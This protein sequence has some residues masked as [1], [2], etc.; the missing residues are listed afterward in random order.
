M[1]GRKHVRSV[2][3]ILIV[4]IGF[5]WYMLLPVSLA[6]EVVFLT[7]PKGATLSQTADSLK[8]AGVIRSAAAFKMYMRLRGLAGDIKPGTHR[9]VKRLPAQGIA[10]ELV[11]TVTDNT[12]ITV[13]EGFTIAQIQERYNRL[14]G[15]EGD[16]FCFLTLNVP[17]GSVSFIPSDSME[18]YLFPD[19]YP[20]S[21]ADEMGLIRQMTEN[22]ERKVILN[23][24][25][26]IAAAGR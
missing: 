1:W 26:E 12:H 11:K 13:P 4:V 15:K 16:R 7:V 18:G 3:T 23:H 19:T 2:M 9:F 10:A 8:E 22:F 24:R 6:N 25:V 14:K 5:I 21:E 17:V 20:I